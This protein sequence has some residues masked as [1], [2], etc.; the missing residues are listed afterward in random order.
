MS[1]T[2]GLVV[3]VR[4]DE[5]VRLESQ[6][7][8]PFTVELTL[9]RKSGPFARLRISAPK[10][11]VRIA[12]P[13]R[14][15]SAGGGDR[16]NALQIAT[17]STSGDQVA[18]QGTVRAILGGRCRRR[19]TGCSFRG[20]FPHGCFHPRLSEP[21]PIWDADGTHQPAVNF[22]LGVTRHGGAAT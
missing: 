1:R 13:P 9:E 20:A 5:T 4:V 16:R 2:A 7:G 18:D 3:D 21:W 11:T 12:R 6:A 8:V 17:T 10:D 19:I 15:F 14:E 22:S